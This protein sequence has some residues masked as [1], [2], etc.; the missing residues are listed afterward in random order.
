ALKSWVQA[1]GSLVTFGAASQWV[2]A[3]GIA[4]KADAE[5]EKEKPEN[6]RTDFADRQDVLSEE[7]SSGNLVSADVDIT[8]PLA[9]GVPDRDLFV[10]KETDVLLP[11]AQDRFGNVVRIDETPLVNGYL[12]HKLK[13]KISGA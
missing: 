4:P 12:P 7:R 10:N 13:E 11:P 9:F 8:H 1:G 6:A 3:K 2:L 5:D